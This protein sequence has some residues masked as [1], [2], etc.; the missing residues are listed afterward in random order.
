[1]HIAHRH[2]GPDG[3]RQRWTTSE[4]AEPAADAHETLSVVVLFDRPGDFTALDEALFSVAVQDHEALDVIVAVADAGPRYHRR[5][6][7]VAVAQPWPP[8]T[9]LR[10]SSVATPARPVVS[11]DLVNAG[12][13]QAAGR[14]VALMHHQDLVYQ[15][16]WRALIER[17]RATGAPVAFGGSQVATH[18]QGDRH[19]MVTKKSPVQPATARLAAVIDGHAALHAFV[20][21]R[22]RLDPDRL[23][24]RQP[25]SRLSVTMFLLGLA[26]HPRADFALAGRR[27]VESRIP[28]RGPGLERLPSASQLLAVLANATVRPD[29]LPATA[30]LAGLVQAANPGAPPDAP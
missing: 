20:A 4:C 18:I 21:D 1:M 11:G 23:I 28:P 13:W 19:W 16:A 22:D 30:L 10:V 2:E 3:L 26:L 6:E 9:R 17:L 25:R 7:T 5:V 24:V 14:Y 15:H 27:M 8:G 29:A 12:L